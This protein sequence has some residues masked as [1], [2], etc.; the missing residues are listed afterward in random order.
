MAQCIWMIEEASRLTKV[1]NGYQARAAQQ[2]YIAT[3]LKEEAE[4]IGNGWY[5]MEEL[6]SLEQLVQDAQSAYAGGAR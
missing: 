6:P 2:A 1:A 3:Y 5:E 4:Y